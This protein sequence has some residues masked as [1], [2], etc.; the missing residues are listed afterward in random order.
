MSDLARDEAARPR[1]AVVAAVV[2]ALA[3]AP[4]AAQSPGAEPVPAPRTSPSRPAGHGAAILLDQANYWTA[5]GRPQLAQQ[6]LDRLLLLEPNNPEVLATAAEV[7][8]QSGDRPNAEGYIVRLNGVAP[9]SAAAHRAMTAF[10][11][12]LVDQP[13][14]AEARRL[15]Q[16]GQREAAMQK[17]REL[18]PDGE[19]P[20]IFA[21]EYFQTLAGT[22][23][24][25]FDLARVGMER[26]IALHPANTALRLAH[27]QI[28][29]Y[30]EAYRLTGAEHL[31]ALA[32]D[33]AMGRAARVAWRQA[34]LWSPTDPDTAE[35]IG[36]YLRTNPPDPEIQAKYDEARGTVLPGW[37]L[38]R[39]SGWNA[40][41]ERRF[42]DAE[43][44]F[45]AVLEG[46]PTDAEAY[47]GLCVV[48][49]LQFRFAEARA[50]FAKA[51]ELAPYREEEF[52]EKTGNLDGFPAARPGAGRGFRGGRGVPAPPGSAALAWQNLGRNALDRA[53]EQAQRALRGNAEERLQGEVVLG[54]VALRRDDFS[55]A[56]TRFRNALAI[57]PAEA[58]AQGGL[59]EALQRQ[60]RFAD[61]DRLLAETGFRP[62]EGARSFRAAALR[63]EAQRTRDRDARIALLRGAVAADPADAW[64]AFDL[65]RNLKERGQLDEARRLERDLAARGTPDA[66][67]AASLLSNADGRLTETVARL[68]AIPPAARTED[69]RRLLEANR[70]AL[71]VRELERAA[72]GNPAS[73]AAR[74]LVALAAQPDPGG[75]TAAAV[76]RAFNRLRQPR[77]AEAAARAAA[78][79]PAARVAVA[80]AL[81]EGGLVA[82]A[83]GL[84]AGVERDALAPAELRRQAAGLRAASAASAADRLNDG[85]DRQGAMR[86]LA[87]ALGQAPGNADVQLS[88]ARVLAGSGRAEEALRIADGILGASPENVRARAVAGEAAVLA[89]EIGRAEDILREGR[90]RG[91]DELQM[92]LLEARIARARDD[93]LRARRALEEAARLRARQLQASN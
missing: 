59:F 57:R 89:K 19:I 44:H 58:S 9:G 23:P 36:H 13:T 22:S 8:A 70:R 72:R 27:A 78:G 61:A 41:G 35:A 26:L 67:F 56:E 14:L 81:L 62:P 11:A 86:R 5:Q 17:Y 38:E 54:L 84:S 66:L 30:S 65:A 73:E 49:K 33:P 40:F 60:G 50:F 90:E 87:P 55:T 92:A 1:R 34:L 83:E 80:A 69:G 16:A 12:M 3:G 53:A 63:G 52:V 6:A 31:R 42:D 82:E 4:A 39:I 46:D 10:R 71:E 91:A 48:R 25:N 15:A 2:A 74:R 76:I 75:E 18:F 32:D 47:I 77:N 51:V 68:D 45:R 43:R 37:I 24:E 93:R 28:L 64:S 20:P 29:T 88:L 79:T 85:G 7:A 21:V